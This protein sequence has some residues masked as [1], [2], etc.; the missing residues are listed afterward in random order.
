MKK[1]IQSML[2]G[3]TG[4]ISS[5]RVITSIAFLLCCIA[6]LANIFGEIPLQQYIWE[7]MLYLVGAGLGFSTLEHFSKPNSNKEE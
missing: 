2:S 3:V 4:N 1:F 5:K 7:G 6:F